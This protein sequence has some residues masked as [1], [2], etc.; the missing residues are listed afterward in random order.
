M[1]NATLATTA[2]SAIRDAAN[3]AGIL[4][5]GSCSGLAMEIFRFDLRAVGMQVS[6]IVRGG[7]VSWNGRIR[8]EAIIGRGTVA[9][10]MAEVIS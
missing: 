8:D 7:V 2:I 3:N 6:G 1:N 10:L 9:Q 5:D 4:F